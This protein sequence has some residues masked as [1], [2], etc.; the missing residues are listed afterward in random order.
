MCLKHYSLCMS[1]CCL[2]FVLSCRSQNSVSDYTV[3]LKDCVNRTAGERI[4]WLS[5]FSDEKPEGTVKLDF[6]DSIA[7][8]ENGLIKYGLLIDKERQSY[9]GLIS[10]LREGLIPKEAYLKL[11]NTFPTFV[12]INSLI[13]PS[14]MYE[15]CPLNVLQTDVLNKEKLA[16]FKLIYDK[17]NY[18]GH[19]SV[20]IVNEVFNITDFQNDIERLSLCNLIYF[21]LLV[22]FEG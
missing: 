5:K 16:S 22:K 18:V 20:D 9:S 2:V 15:N 19:P 4:N 10:R 13:G 3:A 14:A 21:N 8:F 6:Y 7:D 12:E 17:I 11:K 1:V